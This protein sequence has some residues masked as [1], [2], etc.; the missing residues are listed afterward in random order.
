MDFQLKHYGI[1][2]PAQFQPRCPEC[3]GY[4]TLNIMY[5]PRG[6]EGQYLAIWY[7]LKSLDLSRADACEGQ[8]AFED[9]YAR[10]DLPA[11]VR[12]HFADVAEKTFE[13]ARDS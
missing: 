7:C 12:E 6:H 3:G 8:V 9:W 2:I 5:S 13:W 1:E 10:E 11:R 4:M